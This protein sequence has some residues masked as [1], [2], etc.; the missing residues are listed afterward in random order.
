MAGRESSPSWRLGCSI[1]EASPCVLLLKPHIP[2]QLRHTSDA[3]EGRLLQQAASHGV[4][5]RRIVF[6]PRLPRPAHIQR[7]ADSV[8]LFVDNHLYG[9]HSTATDT[10]WA[11]VPLVAVV[12][13]SL[14]VS[15][16]QLLLCT[17]VG[18]CGD[19]P[20]C[21]LWGGGGGMC[22]MQGHRM[23]RSCNH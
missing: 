16:A 4:D 1:A 11:G 8:D 22:H 10:L 18:L 6:K 17:G 14:Q 9:A 21:V 7:L 5:P 13:P 19:P 15:I 2:V 3:S 20:V 23:P 12:S